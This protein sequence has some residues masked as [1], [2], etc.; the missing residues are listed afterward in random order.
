MLIQ[1]VCRR[2]LAVL[3]AASLLFPAAPI[4]RQPSEATPSRI[5]TEIAQIRAENA[6]IRDELRKIEDRNRILLEQ[7]QRLKRVCDGS[8]A[9]VA[10]GATNLVDAPPIL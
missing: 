6:A 4:K 3:Q 8:S 10:E 5:Q 9:P 2:C 1:L 7:M